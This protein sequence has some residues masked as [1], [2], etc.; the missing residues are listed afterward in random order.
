LILPEGFSLIR[1]EMV[2]SAL[3]ENFPGRALGTGAAAMGSKASSS[4][5]TPKIDLDGMATTS[6][7]KNVRFGAA[8][9]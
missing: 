3:L 2:V 9:V 8:A 7:Q 1:D 4:M 5:G 6:L